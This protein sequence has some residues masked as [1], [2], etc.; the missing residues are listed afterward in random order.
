M[1]GVAKRT[2][3]DMR[4][5][6]ISPQDTNYFVVLFAPQADGI[7]NIFVIEIF[8]KGG[9][10]PPNSHRI[11][12]EFF[13]VLKGRGVAHADG[14]AVPLETGE[15]L[16]LGPGVEHVVENT[17]EG[18]LYTLTAMSPNEGFAELILAGAPVELDD[19]DRAVLSGGMPS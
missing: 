3:R 16:M 19:E 17:G 4:A 15:A 14:R 1:D 10:T 7:D 18:K 12:H 8:Q 5:F 13:F 9:K 11:A 6:R 2:A